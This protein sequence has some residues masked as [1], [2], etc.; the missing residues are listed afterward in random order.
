MTEETID[1][2]HL[3]FHICLPNQIAAVT[4][5]DQDRILILVSG[6]PRIVEVVVC[7]TYDRRDNGQ[8]SLKFLCVI[9]VNVRVVVC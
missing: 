7:E 9:R 2:F 4:D 6:F 1:L 8:L 3:S 5:N